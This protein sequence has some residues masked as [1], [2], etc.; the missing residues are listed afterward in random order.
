MKIVHG[1]SQDMLTNMENYFAWGGGVYV[2]KDLLQKSNED[3]DHVLM[4]TLDCARKDS[5]KEQYQHY[6]TKSLITEWTP[7]EFAEIPSRNLTHVL[8]DYE[9]FDNVYCICPYSCKYLNN[10]YGYNKFKYAPCWFTNYTVQNPFEIE[11]D[12]DICYVG[13]I[14]LIAHAQAIDVMSNYKYKF[15]TLGTCGHPDIDKYRTHQ[16]LLTSEKYYQ[17][18]TCRISLNINMIDFRQHHINMLMSDHDIVQKHRAFNNIYSGT[19]PQFKMRV[20]ESAS[21]G[22]LILC[23]R[24]NWNIIEDFYEEGKEFIYYDESEELHDIIKD[25]RENWNNKYKQITKNAYNR[26]LQY[27][28][29]NLWDYIKTSDKNLITW[30][31]DKSL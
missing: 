1:M 12:T 30:N 5:I 7:C 20:H 16:K 13:G 10:L 17:M 27:T 21:V 25:V 19:A 23:K 28:T 15:L 24:D 14:H 29:D 4:V 31:T 3:S 26:Y 18:V 11:K 2:I 8:K 9:Y 6:K 22:A